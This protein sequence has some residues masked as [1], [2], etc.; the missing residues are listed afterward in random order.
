[1]MT[2]ERVDI[3]EPALSAQDYI[4]FSFLFD[5]EATPRRADGHFAASRMR[6]LMDYGF[7]F[8]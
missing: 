4:S 3:R 1:M 8:R 2:A 6:R 5:E 7:D